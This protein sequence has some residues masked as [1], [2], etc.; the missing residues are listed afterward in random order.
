MPK[1]ELRNLRFSDAKRIYEIVDNPNFVYFVKPLSLEA[2]KK[3]LIKKRKKRGLEYN[4][5]IL[6]DKKL[7]G[8]IGIKIDYHRSYVGEI[9]YFVEEKFW[10]KGIATEAVYLM[11]EIAF[12]RLRLNRIEILMSP[13]NIA[14]E[15]VAIK[16]GYKKEGVMS[17]VVKDS[18]GEFFDVLLYAKT[19]KKK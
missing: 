13:K 15:K 2:Y 3:L 18:K 9:N 7:V 4:H 1:T 16:A 17:G 6:Y 10:G 12:Q 14:S 19:K 11:E 5:A 8:N